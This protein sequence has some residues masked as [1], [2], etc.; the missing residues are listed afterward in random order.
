VDP[1]NRGKVVGFRNF[2]G[3]IVM[4]V[5]MLLGNY[6]YLEGLTLGVPQLPFYTAFGL[7]IPQLLIILL[8]VHEPRERVGMTAGSTPP[9]SRVE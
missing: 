9:P 5:G 4:G 6:L 3:Y 1:V 2:V 7:V 8:L